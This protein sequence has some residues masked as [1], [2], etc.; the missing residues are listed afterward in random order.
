[1]SEFSIKTR[2]WLQAVIRQRK[3]LLATGRSKVNDQAA[4]AAIADLELYLGVYQYSK[5]L[6]MAAFINGHKQQIS[7]ILPGA[8][9][10]AHEKKLRE[11]NALCHIS[12]GII[13]AKGV[14][15]E[16]VEFSN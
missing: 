3:M 1:M 7:S 10:P 8:G 12:E 15:Q 11:Y 5:P 2:Q 9:A 13:K 6:Q 4:R 14:M 16:E